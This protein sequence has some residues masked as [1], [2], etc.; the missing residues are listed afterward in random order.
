LDY[1]R[2]LWVGAAL[3]LPLAACGEDAP[4]VVEMYFGTT[5]MVWNS[6]EPASD[7]IADFHHKIPDAA[8]RCQTTLLGL[9]GAI[10]DGGEAAYFL[11]HHDP[12]SA[13]TCL[14]RALP[15]GHFD[16]IA[17]REWDRLT[18]ENPGFPM[19]IRLIPEQF[20]PPLPKRNSD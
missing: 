13:L 12:E 5:T 3:I 19:S 16:L 2:T 20:E 4:P 9:S 10:T 6:L 17:R 15:Q 1:I 18:K 7:Y 14:K 11:P 8:K